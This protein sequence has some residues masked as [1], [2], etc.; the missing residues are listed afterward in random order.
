MKDRR[1]RLGRLL[2]LGAVGI[3]GSS[4]AFAGPPVQLNEASGPDSCPAVAALPSG[5]FVGAW[6]RSGPGADIFGRVFDA[7]LVPLGPEIP[8]SIGTVTALC[9]EVAAFPSG[10]FLVA[11]AEPS[12]FAD[13]VARLFDA[14][15]APLGA[16]FQ[17]NGYSTSAQW[18]P[19]ATTLSSGKVVLT[20][21]SI[22]QDGDDEG[23]F[24][25]RYDATGA[26]L[27]SEFQVNA[28]TT[29]VQQ[30]P[31]VAAGGAGGFIVVWEAFEGTG[32][33]GVY[34]RRY[35]NLGAPLG[36][37][38]QVGTA[39]AF[40]LYN[41]FPAVAARDD[42]GFIVAWEAPDGDGDGI[43]ARVYDGAAVP[44]GPAF[45]VN[46]DV[47]A[48]QI[49]AVAA[50]DGSRFLILWNPFPGFQSV[51]RLLD[52]A[53]TPLGSAF[54]LQQ[55]GVAAVS[56]AARGAGAGEFLVAWTS[57]GAQNADDDL[58]VR[59]LR[60][61]RILGTRCSLRATAGG[62]RRFVFKAS[63]RTSPNH[64]V[65]DP[66]SSGAT[67]RV[68][69]TGGAPS[70]QTFSL[71]ATHWS[72]FGGGSG[73]RYDDPTQTNGP[74]RSALV[75]RRS[76]GV[77]LLKAAV[78]GT[79]PGVQLVPPNPGNSVVMALDLAG[80]ETYCAGFG[81]GQGGG[82]IGPNDA[83]AFQVRLPSAEGSC[84]P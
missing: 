50:A 37:E 32:G 75:Q 70:D 16:P 53:G 29:G 57:L 27:G 58:L 3:L 9:P 6:L 40:P 4:P 68:V 14:T 18:F 84:P 73:Y 31:A 34:G 80:G 39:P 2:V 65:G 7:D 41:L 63:E 1:E 49:G 30:R 21:Q 61:G 47:T 12:T 20:W 71:P 8:A 42:G 23:V 69:T 19:A 5:G 74:V 36:G 24:A 44:L 77:F 45:V 13:V 35:D 64:V 54:R 51:G 22:G 46:P 26:A 56:S 82:T 66:A 10:E 76:S 59:R 11:W 48:D 79:S 55:S 38:F 17:V 52:G 81:V 72:A 33:V 60:P 62:A 43:L 78:R 67:L 28:Y 15:G 25:R 83:G